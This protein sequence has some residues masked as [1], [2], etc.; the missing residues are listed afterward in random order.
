MELHKP[1]YHESGFFFRFLLVCLS[2]QL[3]NNEVFPFENSAHPTWRA[4]EVVLGQRR[5]LPVPV[6]TLDPQVQPKHTTLIPLVLYGMKFEVLD[7][8]RVNQS[9]L[10]LSSTLH[11]HLLQLYRIKLLEKLPH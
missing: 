3:H 1:W 8:L 7:N 6:E 4:I 9:K 5:V 10:A 2:V 11:V